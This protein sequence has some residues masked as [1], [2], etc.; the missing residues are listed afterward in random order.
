MNNAIKIN[1]LIFPSNKKNNKV[2]WFDNVE[3]FSAMSSSQWRS[4]ANLNTA[5]KIYTIKTSRL[6]HTFFSHLSSPVRSYVQHPSRSFR[7]L[8][9]Y[10]V[11]SLLIRFLLSTYRVPFLPSSL[12]FA[13]FSFLSSCSDLVLKSSDFSATTLVLRNVAPLQ[14]VDWWSGITGEEMKKS[15]ML[16]FAKLIERGKIKERTMMIKGWI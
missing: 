12:T 2:Y 15:K 6:H 10:P 5:R 13:R 16:W 3:S 1:I 14:A 4:S 9:K 8:S 11:A 7:H